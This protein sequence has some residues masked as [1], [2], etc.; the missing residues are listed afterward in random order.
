MSTGPVRIVFDCPAELAAAI[1]SAA[2]GQSR[3]AWII[4][5]L[6]AVLEAEGVASVKLEQ[7]SIEMLR[8][9]F[10]TCANRA[11]IEASPLLC[12]RVRRAWRL[13]RRQSPALAILR[14]LETGEV[15][16]A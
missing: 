3:T 4:R 7:I 13:D 15:P 1:K 10:P 5:A 8:G 11:E 9:W 16:A 14:A 12:E 6:E 2:G